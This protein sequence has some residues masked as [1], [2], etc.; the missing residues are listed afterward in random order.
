MSPFLRFHRP[1][2]PTITMRASNY[3]RDRVTPPGIT[4]SR[5][6]SHRDWADLREKPCT[7]SSLIMPHSAQPGD[8]AKLLTIDRR[9][10]RQ[11]A[12]MSVFPF[13]AAPSQPNAT[14]PLTTPILPPHLSRP[15]PMKA[16]AGEKLLSL[17]P[18][19]K[20]KE[21]IVCWQYLRL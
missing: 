19:C 18:H 7:T 8:E 6:G 4:T 12:S 3:P 16:A 10:I 17:P 20:L 14:Q 1:S 13:S 9:R 21:V 15:A 11:P 5:T 2:S